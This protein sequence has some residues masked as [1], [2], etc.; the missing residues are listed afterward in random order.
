MLDR[1]TKN[2]AVEFACLLLCGIASGPINAPPFE[3]SIEMF[4]DIIDGL[5]SFFFGDERK[6][7]FSEGLGNIG[8]V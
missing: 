1:S 5:V 4:P 6:H 8:R 7:L 3:D 2:S